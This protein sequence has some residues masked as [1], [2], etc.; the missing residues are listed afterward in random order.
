MES[1]LEENKSQ[2]EDDELRGSRRRIVAEGVRRNLESELTRSESRSPELRNMRPPDER[3]HTPKD[4]AS[5]SPFSRTNSASSQLANSRRFTAAASASAGDPPHQQQLQQQPKRHGIQQKLEWVTNAISPAT[6]FETRVEPAVGKATTIYFDGAKRGRGHASVSYWAAWSCWRGELLPSTFSS[7]MAEISG[8]IM[9]LKDCHRYRSQL[10]D[11]DLL[12]IIGDS[13]YAI[14]IANQMQ[15]ADESDITEVDFAN[16]D[17]VRDLHRLV[18]KC[19]FIKLSFRQVPRGFNAC[20]D[21]CCN[22]VLSDRAPRVIANQSDTSAFTIPDD[23]AVFKSIVRK[24]S[25]YRTLPPHALPQWALLLD[26]LAE[27]NADF[28]ASI[29]LCAPAIFLRRALCS[30]GAITLHLGRLI[31]NRDYRLSTIQSFLHCDWRSSLAFSLARQNKGNERSRLVRKAQRLT[32]LGAHSKALQAL[33]PTTSADNVNGVKHLFPDRKEEIPETT[34]EVSVK[35][36]SITK[37]SKCISRRI[38]KASAPGLDGWT[39]ELLLPTFSTKTHGAAK[40]YLAEVIGHIM[41]GKRFLSKE[42]ADFLRLGSLICLEKSP[43]KYRPIVLSSVF[44]KI[45]WRCV[46]DSIRVPVHLAVVQQ[47]RVGCQKLIHSAQ[48]TLDKGGTLFQFDGANA[49]GEIKRSVIHKKLQGTEELHRLLPMFDLLYREQSFALHVSSSGEVSRL[50]ASEGVLQ[51]DVASPTLFILGLSE[52]LGPLQVSEALSIADDLMLTS[53]LTNRKST[54]QFCKLIVTVIQS[55]EAVGISSQ[56]LKCKIIGA[57]AADVKTELRVRHG[58]EVST[59]ISTD[60]LGGIISVPHSSPLALSDLRA[61]YRQRLSAISNFLPNDHLPSISC[62]CAQHLIVH[63]LYTLTYV[64]STTKPSLLTTVANDIHDWAQTCMSSIINIPIQET[65]ER[66]K[67]I[68]LPYEHG[69]FNILDLHTYGPR[70]YS[71]TANQFSVKGSLDALKS[72]AAWRSEEA[73]LFYDT[74]YPYAEKQQ[75]KYIHQAFCECDMHWINVRPETSLL[76]LEDSQWRMNAKL[77]LFKEVTDF[78]VCSAYEDGVVPKYHHALNCQ[79]C[80]SYTTKARHE[81]VLS[82]LCQV[83]REHGI[84][85]STSLQSLTLTR[86]DEGPDAIVYGD[87][88]RTID[89]HVNYQG[90]HSPNNVYSTAKQAAHKINKYAKFSEITEWPFHPIGFSALGV[91]TAS[92]ASF[93]KLITRKSSARGLLRRVLSSTAVAVARGNSDMIA[94]LENQAAYLASKEC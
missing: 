90:P 33:N 57:K 45:A 83:L 34:V 11:I 1:F 12:E 72:L 76:T 92:V 66:W 37:L 89:I 28:R 70:L 73:D 51:G 75:A 88:V 64:F 67:V 69:G 7:N 41:Q 25:I 26:T 9:I 48:S 38:A 52:S 61:K 56:E 6:T 31:N 54:E 39:R 32:G 5:N 4:K 15:D 80:L 24:Q 19:S 43:G 62:Q 2:L 16:V 53:S 10:A 65:R 23:E 94:L 40:L 14:D 8:L 86:R 21:E 78:P 87:V 79:Q 58:R 29:V 50:I 84:F 81:R 77:R 22:A 60:Y 85:S 49:F 93:V 17:L 30:L 27:K 59:T 55:L 42:M 71:A 91:P 44:T 82:A 36:A 20:A 74:D 18:H 46:L 13:T 3:R 47:Y 68:S 63:T 35:S